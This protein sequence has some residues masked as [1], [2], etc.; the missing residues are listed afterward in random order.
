M[1]LGEVVAGE[2]QVCPMDGSATLTIEASITITNCVI[3][4]SISARFFARGVNAVT[5]H[6]LTPPRPDSDAKANRCRREVR[7]AVGCAL[8][9]I[10]A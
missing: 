2:V 9:S 6:P 4:S 1:G 5:A 3:A 10:A 7:I 8:N